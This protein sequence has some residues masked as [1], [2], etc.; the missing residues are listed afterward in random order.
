M[1]L[2]INEQ[3]ELLRLLSEGG[4]GG[5]TGVREPRRPKPESP[6]DAVAL[7]TETEEWV[8]PQEWLDRWDQ[9]R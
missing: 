4:E 1:S 2:S 5:G 9:E 3:R 8:A 7:E 6:G